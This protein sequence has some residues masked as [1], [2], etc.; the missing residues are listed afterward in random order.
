MYK[1]KNVQKRK[2]KKDAEAQVQ[3]HDRTQPTD[4]QPQPDFLS[5][6]T[7]FLQ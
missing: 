5:G 7:I 4:A 1:H 6:L 2:G 3:T